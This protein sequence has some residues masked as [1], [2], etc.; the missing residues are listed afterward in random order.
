MSDV[1]RGRSLESVKKEAK[2]WLH[3][4]RTDD[5]DARAR[6]L[7]VAPTATGAVTLREVQHALAIDYGMSGWSAL[8]SQL[9]AQG[10]ARS[11]SL[12]QYH[13]KV[14]ALLDAYRTGTPAAMERHYRLTWHR[15]AWSTMRTYVQIDLGKVAG[16]D[17]TITDDDARWLIAREHGFDDWTSLTQGVANAAR[18]AQLMAKPMAILRGAPRHDADLSVRSRS[19][20]DVLSELT[21][22]EATGLDAHGQF[23]DEMA[24]DVAGCTHL[25]WLRLS[26]SEALTNAG[27]RLLAT[28]PNLRYLDVGGTSITNDGAIAL[29]QLRE[30]E[31]VSLAWT[32]VS[33]RGVESLAAC[34]A[35]EHVDLNGS[36][37]GDGAMRTFAGKERLRCFRS[38]RSTTD[39]GLAALQDYPVF[40]A[41]HEGEPATS[42]LSNSD[43]PNE[44][45]LRGA[46][47]DRGMDALRG[48]EGL[49]GLNLDD[50]AL[51]ITG[52]GLIPLLDLPRLGRLAFNA[53]DDAMPIVARM[54]VLGFFGCQDTDASDAAWTS[55]GGSQSIETI[56]GRRCHGLSDNGFRA[57]S[58]MPRLSKLS[59]SCLNVSDDAVSALPHFPALRELMPMD[60]PDAG[61][62]HIGQCSSLNSLVLMYCRDTTDAATE[63]LMGLSALTYYFAS[64]TQITD[65][66]PA[67]LSHLRSLERITLDSCARVTNEGIAQLAVL[68]KLRELRVSGR[69]ITSGVRSAFPARV[70]VHYAL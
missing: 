17:A 32:R 69:G 61:Y 10:T 68:P 28:M 45:M 47:T 38:G 44:L 66:T 14:D 3:A 53:H 49:F 54:P 37:C 1:L 5:V 21:E 11:E 40:K 58:G 26:G 23:T 16:D 36:F 62:R 24:R 27:V 52:N 7:R 9:L 8:T 12:A 64:Y 22:I 13:E 43:G 34:H 2:Q 25:T 4:L 6:L 67:L 19:W 50:S 15:R 42:L 63:H 59:V 39:A 18:P 31:H 46:I 55:L 51:A 29:G 56:W 57:L 30:L 60:I 33:D 48:L 35:L 20:S 65:R 41:W 70:V